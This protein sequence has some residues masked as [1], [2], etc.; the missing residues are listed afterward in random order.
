[1]K[2]CIIGTLNKI[3]DESIWLER[4]SMISL[5]D[6]VVEDTREFSYLMSLFP[7]LKVVIQSYILISD[8]F[9]M[10]TVMTVHRNT[11]FLRTIKQEKFI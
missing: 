10:N 5:E 8:I 4:S 7:D 1:M 9:P 3:I 2:I 11:C 6:A